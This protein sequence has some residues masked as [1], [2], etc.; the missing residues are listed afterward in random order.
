MLAGLSPATRLITIG[1]PAHRLDIARRLGVTDVVAL[2]SADAAGR[3]DHVMELTAGRGADVVVEAT[4][5][6]AA[7]AE[8]IDMLAVEGSYLVVGLFSGGG[9]V[10]F[11]PVR[12]NNRSQRILGSLSSEPNARIRPLVQR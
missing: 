8:G 12:L 2:E 6:P 10:P 3:H 11:D 7:F 4:G 9:R 1:A 5:Q